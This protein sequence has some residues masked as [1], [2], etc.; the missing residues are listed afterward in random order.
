MLIANRGE[1]ACRVMERARRMGIA[2]V[3]V[4]ADA[5]AGAELTADAEPAT[6]EVGADDAA[7][8]DGDAD[9]PAS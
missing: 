8:D 3:G 1:I 2:T 6:E 4:Y 7:A 5:D 9:K